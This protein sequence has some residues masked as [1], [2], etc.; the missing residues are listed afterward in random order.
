MPLVPDRMLAAVRFALPVPVIS[1]IT[2]PLVF[3]LWF[4]VPALQLENTT[5][6]KT[7]KIEEI[8]STIHSAVAPIDVVLAGGV[9]PIL[10]AWLVVLFSIEQKP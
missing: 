10:V 2:P 7:G 3:I 1:V 8:P 4:L 5:V 6:E 9:I